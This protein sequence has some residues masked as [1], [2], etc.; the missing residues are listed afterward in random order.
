MLNCATCV[1]RDSGAL[2]GCSGCGDGLGCAMGYVRY[3]PRV[4]KIDGEV[5]LATKE[6]LPGLGNLSRGRF[7]KTPT[8]TVTATASAPAPAPAPVQDVVSSG[9]DTPAAASTIPQQ[10]RYTKEQLADMLIRGAS[11]QVERSGEDENGLP[12]AYD[13]EQIS[14][15][16]DATKQFGIDAEGGLFP[17]VVA[18]PENKAVGW[19][20]AAA[21]AYFMIGG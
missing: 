2:S 11:E 20:I 15:E 7:W 14:R 18:M 16:N 9:I 13:L 6:I 5:R 10:F 17:E 12:E 3:R 21:V 1:F 4:L 8:Q 19:L